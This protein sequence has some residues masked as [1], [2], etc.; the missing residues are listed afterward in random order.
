VLGSEQCASGS[1]TGRFNVLSGSR[2]GKEFSLYFKEYV[3]LKTTY[4]P[5]S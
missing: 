4:N 1:C 2:K 5:G 3:S